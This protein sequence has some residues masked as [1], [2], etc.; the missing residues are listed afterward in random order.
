MSYS[1]KDPSRREALAQLW[2]RLDPLPWSGLASSEAPASVPV[3]QVEVTSSQV[4]AACEVLLIKP[5]QQA[6]THAAS[7]SRVRRVAEYLRQ[8]EELESKAPTQETAGAL[9]VGH[10]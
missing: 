6:P 4:R 1:K 3:P 9:E 7:L 8:L 10:G 2:Q 5:A